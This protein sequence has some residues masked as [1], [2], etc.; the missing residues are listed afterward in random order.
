VI[1]V[2]HFSD[3]HVSVPLRAMPLADLAGK[4]AIGAINLVLHRQSLFR[5][6]EKKISP[7]NTHPAST[8]TRA[9]P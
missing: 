5:D 8:L 3:V 2:L 1:R 4:R 6:A 9:S 7:Y